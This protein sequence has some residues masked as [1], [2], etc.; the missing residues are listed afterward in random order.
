MSVLPMVDAAGGRNAAE[1]ADFLRQATEKFPEWDSNAKAHLK[2]LTA[3]HNKRP[4]TKGFDAYL[5][6]FL[7]EM[8]DK[9]KTPK[10]PPKKKKPEGEAADASE[11]PAAKARKPD[12]S[13]ISKDKEGDPLLED[14]G[15]GLLARSAADDEDPK[16]HG[17]KTLADICKE[18]QEDGGPGIREEDILMEKPGG[19]PDEEENVAAVKEAEKRQLRKREHAATKSKLDT[20]SDDD[21]KPKK[22]DDDHKPKKAKPAIKKEPAKPKSE[23]KQQDVDPKS[24]SDSDDDAKKSRFRR[25][26]ESQ[27]IAR[28]EMSRLRPVVQQALFARDGLE[29]KDGSAN[30]V[31]NMH[32]IIAASQ[33]VFGKQEFKNFKEAMLASSEDK[34]DQ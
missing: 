20:E 2:T 21:P 7:G 27:I 9:A 24:D 29:I 34:A 30:R 11:K 10:T 28:F 22:S 12:A 14:V 4:I 8:A 33:L 31:L 13:E 18:I 15:P 25:K 3:Q 32:T 23:R 17:Q 6:R 19:K 5:L 1:R 16:E 26:S